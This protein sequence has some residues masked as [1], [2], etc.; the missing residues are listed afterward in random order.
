MSMQDKAR[1]EDIEDL[2]NGYFRKHEL[3]KEL[4]GEYIYQDDKAQVD[5]IQLVSD[6]CD[7]YAE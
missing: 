5:A 6:I 4:G 2:V 3:A 1:R 7:L